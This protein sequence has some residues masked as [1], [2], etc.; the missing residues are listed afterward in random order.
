MRKKII[1]TIIVLLLI[2]M[3]LQIYIMSPTLKNINNNE[4]SKRDLKEINN[5]LSNS[6]FV[7]SDSLE[8]YMNEMKVFLTAKEV[9]H[10]IEN[11][12]NQ[13]FGIVGSVELDD[14]YNY[15]FDSSFEKDYFCVTITPQDE[16]YSDRWYV[17]CK[18]DRESFKKFY[19]GL[20]E[21][22]SI[23]ARMILQIPKLFYK[24]N[25]GNMAM[26]YSVEWE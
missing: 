23:K 11:N 14:Y 2:I 10:N 16:G 19:D 12:L 21:R 24:E 15:G 9:Q 3:G 25:Q 17:Y 18:R 20:I 6:T 4:I 8:T 22:K 7:S 1:V 13:K 5:T 26:L